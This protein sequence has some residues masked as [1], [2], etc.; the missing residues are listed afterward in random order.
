MSD[1]Q[2]RRL[3][4]RIGDERVDERDAA[5]AAYQALPLVERKSAPAGVVPLAVATVSVDGGRVQIFERPPRAA[6]APAPAAVA[7]PS[8]DVVTAAAEAS[9]AVLAPPGLDP[10]PKA[11]GDTPLSPAVAAPAAEEEDVERRGRFWR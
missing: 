1:K 6:A 11:A 3:C 8:P 10:A 9:P 5:V 4:K 2:V 7:M